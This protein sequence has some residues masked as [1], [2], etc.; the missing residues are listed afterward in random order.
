MPIGRSCPACVGTSGSQGV[1]S[2]YDIGVAAV[3][4]LSWPRSGA[5]DVVIP[6]F[7]IRVGPRRLEARPVADFTKEFADLIV[8][9]PRSFGV[10]VKQGKSPHRLS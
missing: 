6:P 10:R 5:A 7:E 2:W 9:Q 4:V 8:T 1:C 3:G